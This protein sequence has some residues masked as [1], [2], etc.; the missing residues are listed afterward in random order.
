MNWREKLAMAGV[1]TITIGAMVVLTV[2]LVLLL[3]GGM[4]GCDA[5][6][7]APGE[8]AVYNIT[9]NAVDIYRDGVWIGSVDPGAL[10][11]FGGIAGGEY[12]AVELGNPFR[13]HGPLVYNEPRGRLLTWT[14]APVTAICP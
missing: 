10:G 5:S 3:F 8:L 2:L 4:C 12:L 9:P 14:V 7:L 6:F 13:I 1:V 11:R